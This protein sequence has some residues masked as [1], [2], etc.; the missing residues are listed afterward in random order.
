MQRDPTTA[1]VVCSSFACGV[2][3][4]PFGW[5]SSKKVGD[6][7]NAVNVAPAGRVDEL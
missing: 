1:P 3:G 7:G 4:N 2:C 6:D 5:L